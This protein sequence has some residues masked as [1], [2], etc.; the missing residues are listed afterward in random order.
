M[1][2]LVGILLIT[3]ACGQAGVELSKK[4]CSRTK[5]LNLVLA[6][7]NKIETYIRFSQ[8]PTAE[9]FGQ[10]AQESYFD[11]LGF[12]KKCNGY[13]KKGMIFPTAFGKSIDESK[14]Q[15]HLTE[16]DLKIIARLGDI[17]GAWDV[18][19]QIKELKLIQNQLEESLDLAKQEQKTKGKLM[20]SVGL[21][22]GILISIILL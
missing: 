12:A 13:L 8:T 6:M 22:V 18:Q 5:E 2:K 20:K 10:L 14:S 3:F 21:L 9:I 16:S 17:I 4:Y 1:I 7:L 19:G 11:C 15:L